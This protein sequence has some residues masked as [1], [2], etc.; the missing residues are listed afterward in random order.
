MVRLTRRV[1]RVEEVPVAELPGSD[2]PVGMSVSDCLDCWLTVGKLGS[3]WVVL[4]ED[5]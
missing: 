2:W 1:T 5:R 3:M 4:F